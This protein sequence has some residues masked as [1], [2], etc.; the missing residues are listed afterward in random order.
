MSFEIRKTLES[1]LPELERIYDTA[2]RFM[3]SH[4]NHSQWVGYPTKEILLRDIEGGNSFVV[5]SGGKTVAT[6]A[7]FTSPDPTYGFIENGRWINDE[8]YGTIHRIASDGTR[9]GV[10]GFAVEYCSS[11]IKNIRIDTHEDNTVM[12]NALEKLGF[13]KCGTIYL[14][15]GSPRTAYQKLF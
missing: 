10:L 4:G 1:D 15:D 2:R 6:F 13:E 3:R 5:L 14:S 7:F 9:K 8:S 12:K 11:V